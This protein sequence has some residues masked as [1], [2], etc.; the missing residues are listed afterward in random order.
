[1]NIN[2]GT[3]GLHFQLLIVSFKIKPAEPVKSIGKDLRVIKKAMI[4]CA[5]ELKTATYD[6]ESKALN[7]QKLSSDM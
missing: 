6:E 7:G 1:M 5:S 2:Q 4:K 3:A